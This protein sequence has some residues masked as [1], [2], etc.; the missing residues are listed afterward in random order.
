MALTFAT[1]A[2]QPFYSDGDCASDAAS[3]PPFVLRVVASS[4]IG[5]R[6]ATTRFEC[7]TIFA[8]VL[9]LVN[10]YSV[11]ASTRTQDISAIA[12]V[13]ALLVV[14]CAGI[15]H[16]ARGASG[17][18]ANAANF[19]RQLGVV[20]RLWTAA[21]EHIDRR[22][23]KPRRA[24]TRLLSGRLQLCR[25]VCARRPAFKHFLAS[26][27]SKSP[28]GT[29]SIMWPANLSNHTSRQTL[30]TNAAAR[31]LRNTQKFAS[32][33][34]HFASA[35]DDHLYRRKLGLFCR[36]HAAANPRFASCRVYI[37]RAC[38]RRAS[39]PRP[40]VCRRLVHR[41]DKRHNFHVVSH[42]FRRRSRRPTA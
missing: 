26:K 2:L 10:C 28:S 30:P 14:V 4:V 16:S 20:C 21:F 5:E 9:T 42:V 41:L 39:T 25:L 1:Y 8:V 40:G 11:R 38:A 3:I 19:R 37:R 36:P 17:Q 27:T 7:R 15:L 34:L 18:R 23:A 12:K 32:C 24:S 35:D 6:R 22:V 29:T 33:N 31:R 13:G